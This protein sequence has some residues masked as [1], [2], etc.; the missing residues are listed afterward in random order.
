MGKIKIILGIQGII[1]G[2]LI[3]FYLLGML[4]MLGME[5]EL[6]ANDYEY[7]QMLHEQINLGEL[8][9]Y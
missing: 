2:I 1:I 4:A 3:I 7:H 5:L 9:G 6:M 8:N